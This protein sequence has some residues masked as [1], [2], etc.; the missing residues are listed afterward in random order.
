MFLVECFT[1][2]L[3]RDRGESNQALVAV[4]FAGPNHEAS[5][6]SQ[7]RLLAQVYLFTTSV[8]ISFRV[9]DLVSEVLHI[10]LSTCSP[11]AIHIVNLL[12]LDIELRQ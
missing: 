7:E 1:G 9:S 6:L 5:I 4:D 12:V 3:N 10:I 2:V 8:S 11:L